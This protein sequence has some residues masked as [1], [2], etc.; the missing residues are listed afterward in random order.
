MSTVIAILNQKKGSGKTT[1]AIN[2]A[3]ALKQ[4]GYTVFSVSL[5]AHLPSSRC[6]K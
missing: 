3:H 6:P 1:I 4:E 5:H 2:I